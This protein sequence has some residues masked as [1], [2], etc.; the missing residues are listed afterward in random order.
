[1]T[2]QPC[3]ARRALRRQRDRVPRRARA[4]VP[5]TRRDFIKRAA[6]SGAVLAMPAALGA[7]WA[8]DDDD[9]SPSPPAGKERVTLFFNLAHLD[10][11]GRT[12][13]LTGGGR[14]DPL[15]PVA[16][17]PQVLR[18]ARRSNAF[19]AEVEDRYITHHV[20]NRLF[21]TDS[22][23][24]TYVSTD[25]DLAAGTWSMTSMQLHIPTQGAS[26]AY[27]RA[28]QL[29]PQGPL[30]QSN[31]RRFY[32]VAAATTEQDLR[33]ERVLMDTISHAATMVGFHPDLLSIEP[34]AAHTVHSN[35]VDQDQNVSELGTRLMTARFATAE[36]PITPNVPNRTGW[37]TLQPVLDDGGKPLKNTKGTH[38]GRIQYQPDMNLLLRPL[39][40]AAMNLSIP[41]VKDDETLGT[42]V[43]GKVPGDQPDATMT[44]SMWARHDGLTRIDQSVGAAFGFGAGAGDAG[45]TMTLTQQNPQ[46]GY[47]ISASAV[48]SG[49]TQKVSLTLVNWFLEYRG[50]WL[51]FYDANDKLLNLA[52]VPEYV[53]GTIT[54]LHDKTLDTATEM[55]CSTIGGAFT[56]FAIPI[57]PSYA[58][59]G[60]TLPKSASTARV[61][62]SGLSFQGGNAYADTVLPGA[63]LTGMIN[64]GLTA[65]MCAFGAAALIPAA[66]KGFVSPVIQALT[67]ELI[68]AVNSALNPNGDKSLVGQLLMP[69]FWASQALVLAKVLITKAANIGANSAMAKLVA[70]VIP[71]EAE[72]AAED[73]IPVAGQIMQAISIAAGVISLGETTA[74]LAL[75]PWTY[76]DDLVF[77]H[78]LSVTILKDSGNPNADPP[79][80]GDDTFPKAANSYTVTAMFDDGTPYVQTFALPSAVPATLP[81]V[82]FKGVPLGGMVNVSVAFVQ[83]AMVSGQPDVLLGRG[84]T[85]RIGNDDSTISAPI[86]FEIVEQAFPIGSNTVYRHKQKTTLDA[87]QNHVWA[88]G[89]A[90]TVNAGNTVCGAAGTICSYYGI[91][92]RQGT[93]SARGY[94]GY[95]WQSQNANPGKAPSCVGNGTGQLDQMANLN[96]D[97]S[98]GGANAQLGYA[99]GSCGIANPGVKLAYNLLTHG[100]ANYYLDTGDPTAPILRQ[101]TLEPAPQFAGATGSANPG[102]AFGVLNLSSDKLLLHPA[103]HVV[104]INQAASM[105]ET[106]KLPTAGMSD[107]D[108]R[109]QLVAQLKSG[110]GKRPG[111]LD[112]PAAAAISADGVILILEAGNNR[113]QAL[114]IGGNPVQHFTKLSGAGSSPYFLPLTATDQRWTY[115]DMAVE[116]TGYIYVLS[117]RPDTFVY[118]LDIYHPQQSNSQPIATTTAI[119][120]ARLVVDF[121]RNVYTL[122]YEVLTLPN[123][124]SADLTE[125]SVSLWTPCDLGQGCT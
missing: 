56:V 125:P 102:L 33:D 72:G 27:A 17:K 118:Q 82:V 24:L 38:A 64:Y 21:D 30:P 61:L 16:Q 13:Y 112:T 81:P 2:I 123:G 11:A 50:I 25:H 98:Q 95:S 48:P 43:T 5:V 49:A 45:A 54:P 39:A 26:R 78:D 3:P 14:S 101:V 109:T 74:D 116:Y 41:R 97:L 9:D 108:A 57:A 1:M 6:G 36:P 110:P 91:S 69:R 7:C 117:Y 10:T 34:G 20:E 113:I 80:P 73:A 86:S 19:L 83:Q 76:V 122:N 29:N 77:T 96:T 12:Y 92:V 18:K 31:K 37:G 68:T 28:R 58:Q 88:S 40:R 124:S 75:T 121:W 42:D 120:A 111:L 35:Y 46:N 119:N 53:A 65:F 90:P 15:V 79:D 66:I 44:G 89:P 47:R 70:F 71:A 52:D 8:D 100:T 55:W 105:I 85:G 103:G 22:V 114:D 84:T 63:I 87:N 4:S 67:L 115:L 59:P 94:L 32:G 99:N 23:T 106:H 60:F 104:S 51:Q 93:G 62:S 107:A